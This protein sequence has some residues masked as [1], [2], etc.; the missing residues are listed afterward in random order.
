MCTGSTPG[1]E[2]RHGPGRDRIPSAERVQLRA[3][4]T[5][6]LNAA[7]EVEEIAVGVADVDRAV[8]PRHRRWRDD[9]LDRRAGRLP[10]ACE[11]SIDV[12][13][14]EL[15]HDRAGSGLR[16]SVRAGDLGVGVQRPEAKD[17]RSGRELDV[18]SITLRCRLKDLLVKAGETVDLSSQH[19]GVSELGHE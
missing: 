18:R 4:P 7:K 15:E 8:A 2:V 12:V 13:H 3:L 11:L 14:F 16:H 19:A 10:E 6:A 1:Y 9:E 17:A 5:S